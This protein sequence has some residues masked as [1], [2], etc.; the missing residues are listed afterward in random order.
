MTNFRHRKK[1]KK[2]NNLFEA[3]KKDSQKNS[4]SL[5]QAVDDAID[6]AFSK[7]KNGDKSFGGF[8]RD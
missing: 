2:I 5:T 1:L 7:S 3:A 8:S 4:K 6:E